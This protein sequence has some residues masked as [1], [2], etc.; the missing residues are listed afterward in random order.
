[1]RD[2]RR[3]L[4]LA[5]LAVLAVPGVAGADDSMELALEQSARRADSFRSVDQARQWLAEM[6]RRLRHQV[7]NPFYRLELLRLIHREA[8]RSQLA[9]EL[10]MAVIQVESSFNR[11]AVSELGARGLM[12]LMP[13]WMKEIGLPND[14]LFNPAINIRYGCMVLGDYLRRS[15]G[16][17]DLALARYNGSAS[18]RGARYASRV[19]TTMR[20]FLVG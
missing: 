6:S 18:R 16:N 2:A 10:V 19:L 14:D 12:Q 5:G 17:V 4:L 11:Y 8:T 1:M 13:F 3:K 20:S 15:G 7:R 9:P